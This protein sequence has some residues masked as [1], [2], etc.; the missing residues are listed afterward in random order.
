MCNYIRLSLHFN[1][2]TI[3]LPHTDSHLSLF[4]LSNTPV[5]CSLKTPKQIPGVQYKHRISKFFAPG[6]ITST[7]M[8]SST[9]SIALELAA[10]GFIS[11]LFSTNII[12]PAPFL[13]VLWWKNIWYW[14]RAKSFTS[15]LAF[16]QL[17]LILLTSNV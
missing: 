11:Y 7:P 6:T 13:W 1:K 16:I 14:S 15:S 8:F 10:N 2:F 4:I 12:I 9:L 5:I 3:K 17:S